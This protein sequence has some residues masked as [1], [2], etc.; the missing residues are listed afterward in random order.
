MSLRNWRKNNPEKYCFQTLRNNS[1]RRGKDFD[2]TFEQFLQFAAKTNYIL[3]KGRTR[4][5]FHIDRI[6][7]SKGYTIDNIQVLTNAENVKKFL[8]FSTDERGVPNYFVNELVKPS[9]NTA[10]F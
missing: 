7:E 1:K 3:G 8:R 4:E 2:L 9:K 5:S 6:D 10:P